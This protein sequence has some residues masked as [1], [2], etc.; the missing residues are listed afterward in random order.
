MKTIEQYQDEKMNLRRET[1]EEL[2]IFAIDWFKDKKNLRFRSGN[3]T[4]YVETKYK[5][6]NTWVMVN[7]KDNGEF[8]YHDNES[9]DLDFIQMPYMEEYIAF[10][11]VLDDWSCENIYLSCD[12]NY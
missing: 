6:T 10:N 11:E 4:W 5:N 3:G 7:E 1:E 9:D 2:K 12:I 8:G